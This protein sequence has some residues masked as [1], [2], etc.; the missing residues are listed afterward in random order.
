MPGL[1][2]LTSQFTIPICSGMKVNSSKTVNKKCHMCKTVVKLDINLYHF[3][4][5]IDSN[6]LDLCEKCFKLKHSW[7]RAAA[8]EH[9]E[10][11]RRINYD[12]NH[13]RYVRE[14]NARMRERQRREEQGLDRPR[15]RNRR[16]LADILI[17]MPPIT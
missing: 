12:R 17:S 8:E 4:N 6:T 14:A 11:Q 1:R 9:E 2:D 15:Q 13:R 10:L 7:E 5:S 16:S 3:S